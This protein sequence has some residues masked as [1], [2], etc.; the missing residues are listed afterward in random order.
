MGFASGGPTIWNALDLCMRNFVT[1]N[2]VKLFDKFII[3]FTIK[4]IT[5]ELFSARSKK[6][7]YKCFATLHYST[8]SHEILCQ[9]KI[10]CC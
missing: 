7:T 3:F 1:I 10:N 5:A 2:S 6:A 8:R 4:E 9:P